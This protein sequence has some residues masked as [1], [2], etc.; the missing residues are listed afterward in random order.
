MWIKNCSGAVFS[1]L[2]FTLN[3]SELKSQSDGHTAS[4]IKYSCSRTD[5][6]TISYTWQQ[7]NNMGSHQ[8][9]KVPYFDVTVSTLIQLTKFKC[10]MNT[11]GTGFVQEAMTDDSQNI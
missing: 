8:M 10:L 2:G 11:P 9:E 1:N 4:V 6:V 3:S 5:V 7:P